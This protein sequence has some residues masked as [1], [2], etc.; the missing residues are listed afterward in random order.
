MSR[1]DGQR[2][3]KTEEEEEEEE[4]GAGWG[5]LFSFT[6]RLLPIAAVPLMPPGRDARLT[7]FVRLPVRVL[8]LPVLILCR[9]PARTTA[10]KLCRTVG[11]CVL[12]PVSIDTSAAISR[13]ATNVR[14][15]P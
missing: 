6:S 3:K 4:E 13:D 2:E 8:L 10:D 12:L 5:A 11:A 9:R 7:R 14:A 1:R 15:V